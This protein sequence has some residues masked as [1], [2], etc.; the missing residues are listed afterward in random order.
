[1]GSSG[2]MCKSSKTLF[3]PASHGINILPSLSLRLLVQASLVNGESCTTIHSLRTLYLMVT[4][5]N[6]CLFSSG[7]LLHMGDD[8]EGMHQMLTWVLN[9]FFPSWSPSGKHWIWHTV[10]VQRGLLNKWGKKKLIYCFCKL[11]PAP[12]TVW[13]TWIISEPRSQRMFPWGHDGA[14]MAQ[15]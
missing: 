15:D 3:P 12:S 10:G 1:M 2:K 4:S 13:S 14:P 8:A 9:N 11:V 6:T 7:A 5:L